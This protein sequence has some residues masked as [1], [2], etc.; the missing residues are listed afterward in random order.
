VGG[1]LEKGLSSDDG[2]GIY[3]F[4]IVLDFIPGSIK[5]GLNKNLTS[6]LASFKNHK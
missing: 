4:N 5:N 3:S 6:L 2:A 1:I